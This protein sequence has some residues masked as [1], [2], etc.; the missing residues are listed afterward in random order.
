MATLAGYAII[1]CILGGQAISA[2]GDGN[3]SV[4]V[5]IVVLA[6]I[7]LV[8]IFCGSQWIHH[9]DLCAWIPSLVAVIGALGTGGKY[10]HQQV[11]APP[12]TAA[13]VMSYGALVAGFFLPWSAVASDFTTYYDRRSNG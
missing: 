8:V 9:F 12:A 1:G 2:A 5:G 4:N 11:D 6:I 3:V 7:T 10:L 13:L